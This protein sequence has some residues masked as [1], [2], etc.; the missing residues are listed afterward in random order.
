V[1]LKVAKTDPGHKGNTVTNTYKAAVMETGLE[2]QVPLHMNEGDT[3]KINT[4]DGTYVERVN[5]K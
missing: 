2:V 1:V 4:V 3:L 5:L